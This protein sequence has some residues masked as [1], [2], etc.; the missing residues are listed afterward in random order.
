[1]IPRLFQIIESE[2]T[3]DDGNIETER[4]AE[5]GNPD[6]APYESDNIDLSVEYYP[7]HIGVLSAGLFYKDIDNYIVQAE[8]YKTMASGRVFEEGYSTY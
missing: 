5:V 3:E 2:I 4:K 6:L 7:G 1:M 8:K